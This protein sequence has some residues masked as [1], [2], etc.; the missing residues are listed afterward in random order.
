M[1][2]STFLLTFVLGLI[3]SV[4]LSQSH[5]LVQKD[6]RKIV[7]ADFNQKKAMLSHGHHFDVFSKSKMSP[8]EKEAMQFLYAYMPVADIVDY[9]GSFHLMNIRAAERARRE[10][11]WGKLV[12]D[13]LYRHFVV[14]ERVNNEHL[15][16]SRVVFYDQLKNRVKD[17]L[18]YQAILEVNHWCHEKAIYTPSDART[19][20]PLATC[21][22]AYGRCGEESTF[23]V[24][25]LR[26]VGIPARQVYTPRWAHTDDNHAWVEAWA[27]GK[28]Y[29]LGACEP[30]P[31]L[32]LAWFNAPASR[33]MLMHTKVFG[34]Y[35]GPE[36]VMSK[37]ANYTEINV[38][39]NYAPTS[40]VS[41]HV[42]DSLGNQVAGAL[43]EFK[44][45]NYAEFYSVA[46]KITDAQGHCSLTA[47]RGDMIVWASK[48]GRFGFAKVSFGKQK[49]IT[50]SLKHCEGD[51]FSIDFDIV[52][53]KESANLPQV[54]AEQRKVNDNRLSKEDSIRTAYT[55]T[56]LTNET[57][58]QFVSSLKSPLTD[59][60]RKSLI[61]ILIK[62][63][64]NHS[65]LEMFLE[66]SD[67]KGTLD[68]AV[69][70]LNSLSDKDLRD[71]V[72]EVLND[73]LWYTIDNDGREDYDCHLLNPRI[74]Y[75]D[76]TCYKSF[77]KKVIDP[78]KAKS[79]R[80]DPQRL[81]Q[82][83]KVN[84]SVNDSLS[85]QRIPQSPEGV[86][87]SKVADSKSLDS[88]FVAVARSCGI[89][90]WIDE[91]TDEVMY[92]KGN[93]VYKVSFEGPATAAIV[94]Q[95]KLRATYEPNN[96]VDNPK[97]YSHFT[98]SK[99]ENGQL[100]LLSYDENGTT[101][102]NLLK[103]P[104]D[105]A[106][107]YYVMVTG[108]RLANGGVLA[109]M[110]SFVVKEGE[111]TVI[112]LKLRESKDQ[113][114][115]IGNF[116]SESLF[117]PVTCPGK[118]AQMLSKESVLSACGRG[119]YVIG[120]VGPGQE[121]TN[122]ALKDIA[123]LKCK[124]ESWGR[125]IVLLF[126]TMDKCKKF[127]FLEFQGLPKDV[128]FGIDTDGIASQIVDNMKLKLKDQ[129]PIFIIA[130]TFNRVVFV[131]QGYTIGLGDQIMN[132][133]NGL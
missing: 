52:P 17:L 23:L 15:D 33:G 125:K 55:S 65:V 121:P 117:T 24:A 7:Q 16:S 86:W 61:D 68:K 80:E 14:P 122:H 62:S 19:S 76:L 3:P 118:E 98:I 60:L 11:P 71:I 90:A 101:W 6:Y 123:A 67:R 50:V 40:A 37:T 114:Q 27:D 97:Y 21:R 53:P 95:G 18:M 74:K 66:E 9:P 127:N 105:L 102:Q 30:E 129:L 84:I 78:S 92:R 34:R 13:L 43:V 36:E 132:V 93:H 110:T 73:H 96:I 108:M 89:S 58:S 70:L 112:N 99:F 59:K 85:A 120:I 38:I 81:I 5:F 22:T 45:Y 2:L 44:L 31:V 75:E 130:D 104:L 124:L 57:A 113:V 87:T 41:V 1:K 128:V 46:K 82:W 79:Y 72:I 35:N 4:S 42:V 25:A 51:L 107:G 103:K 29:F 28:W 10:M 39:S 48:D 126:P 111:E 47:G 69:H 56:F 12:P 100:K 20:S 49:E 32:N 77:F 64:G 26:S 116:N 106:A 88:F 131:T 119:Y 63:R 8:Y 133:V 94:P 109:N 91:V 54:T 115:V 83:C